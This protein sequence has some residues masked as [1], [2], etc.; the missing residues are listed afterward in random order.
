[1]VSGVIQK[2]EEGAETNSQLR[3]VSDGM[4]LLGAVGRQEGPARTYISLQD[5]KEGK[6]SERKRK[7]EA[8]RGC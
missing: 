6:T 7:L 8:Q 4:T 2:K 3:A 5:S 1:V